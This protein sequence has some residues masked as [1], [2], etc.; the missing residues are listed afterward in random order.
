VAVF[1]QVTGSA[2]IVLTWNRSLVQIQYRPQAAY[3]VRSIFRRTS[4]NVR[5]DYVQSRRADTSHRLTV[6]IAATLINTGGRE[7]VMTNNPQQADLLDYWAET[8][9]HDTAARPS[10]PVS[11]CGLPCIG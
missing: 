4:P 6:S 7:S 11:S 10:R 9:L 5:A 1:L 2:S 3:L 8:D